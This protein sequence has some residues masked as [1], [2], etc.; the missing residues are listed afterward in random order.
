MAQ[1]LRIVLAIA[2]PSPWPWLLIA[3]LS[4]TTGAFLE[5]WLF[6]AQA[7]HLVMLYY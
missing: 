5:R 7:K 1:A 3:T 4:A 2:M 6:F